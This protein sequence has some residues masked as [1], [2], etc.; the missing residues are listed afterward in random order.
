MLASDI[1]VRNVGV[2]PN[3]LFTRNSDWAESLLLLVQYRACF[4]WVFGGSKISGAQ[5][6]PVFW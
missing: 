4:K 1:S 5:D 2:I 3:T 6:R